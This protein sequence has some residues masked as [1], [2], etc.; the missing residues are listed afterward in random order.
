MK[1]LEKSID[2]YT[3]VLGMKIIGRIK[4]DA[5]KG[6]VVNLQSNDDGHVLELNYYEK[7]SKFAT[8]YAVGEGLDHLAFE[9][10]NL[11]HA[12]VE[13]RN[14]GYPTVLEMR[15]KE[16]RWVY[17]VDPNGIYIELVSSG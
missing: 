2:F 17:I 15:R 11:D 3:K 6:E 4:I 13:A 16:S 5:A 9:V 8:R 12:L 10:E 1:N 14:A 7:G